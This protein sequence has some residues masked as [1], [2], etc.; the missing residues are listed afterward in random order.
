VRAEVA[1]MVIADREENCAA[2]VMENE[3]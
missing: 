2:E 1:M 3:I